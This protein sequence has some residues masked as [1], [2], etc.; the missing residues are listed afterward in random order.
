ME[1]LLGYIRR[2]GRIVPIKSSQK[3][4]YDVTLKE[5]ISP[6]IV[7]LELKD[8]GTTWS[9]ASYQDNISPD[10]NSVITSSSI[11]L[12]SNRE[13]S[14]FWLLMYVPNA[15]PTMSRGG[16]LLRKEN[17]NFEPVIVTR[18]NEDYIVEVKGSGCPSGGFPDAHFRIQAGS[19]TGTHIRVTGALGLTG[20]QKE[21]NTLRTITKTA[22]ELDQP[23]HIQAL[24]LASFNLKFQRQKEEFAQLLRL[25]PSSIR[26][27][28]KHNP[29]LDTLNNNAPLIGVETAGIEAVKL[30]NHTPPLF[31]RN[32]SWNNLVYVSENNYALTD[33]EEA[34]HAHIAH[35]NLE[36]INAFYPHFFNN[37]FYQDN[38]FEPYLNAMRSVPSKVERLIDA[39]KP[40]HIRELNDIVLEYIVHPYTYQQRREGTLSK[41]FISDT[42]S[43]VESFLPKSYFKMDLLDWVDSKLRNYLAIKQKL[44]TYYETIRQEHGY[45]TLR[46]LWNSK[47][48]NKELQ[49]SFDETIHRIE[50]NIRLLMQYS[51]RYHQHELGEY[52]SEF[53][54]ITLFYA[55]PEREDWFDQSR[56]DVHHVLTQLD[57]FISN[58]KLTLHKQFVTDN[59][60]N[61][62]KFLFYDITSF[63]CPYLPYIM[64]HLHNEKKLLQSLSKISMDNVISESL[65]EIEKK[66]SYIAN[67]PVDFHK[68]LR[69]D[70]TFLNDYFILCYIKVRKV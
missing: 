12:T 37:T 57:A 60:E 29:E 38:Y 55:I 61:R 49:L 14:P 46:N 69:E 27:S 53:N 42:I 44:L 17:G 32:C 48:N 22:G 11:F 65:Q 39:Y 20:A 62:R 45:D 66:L 59:I 25:S 56:S 47:E 1:H 34:D 23:Q 4:F 67:N 43:Y 31:H 35:C 5:T 28:F 6:V 50:P 30:L 21:F 2:E 16:V 13:S 51:K 52:K 33:Y 24:G 70:R 58:P 7:P 18:N 26:F 63:V 54:L 19:I 3:T 41:T 8:V 36:L 9:V 15:T 10:L 40:K 64:V 68:K